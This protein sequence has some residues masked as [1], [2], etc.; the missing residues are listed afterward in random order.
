M[1]STHALRNVRI[2]AAI[3]SR[4]RSQGP[5]TLE[6]VRGRTDHYGDRLNTRILRFNEIERFE[7][8][9]Q[10]GAE[11]PVAHENRRFRFRFRL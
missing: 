3:A 8:S 4:A 11:A 5:T 10:P 2:H 9:C 7:N 1:V 6:A